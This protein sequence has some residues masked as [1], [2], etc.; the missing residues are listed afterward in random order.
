MLIE[1]DAARRHP[2][3]AQG[4]RLLVVNRCVKTPRCRAYPSPQFKEILGRDF[5]WNALGDQSGQTWSAS[6]NH[7]FSAS[8]ACARRSRKRPTYVSGVRRSRRRPTY[9]SRCQALKETTNLRFSVPGAQRKTRPE[10][11][12]AGRSCNNLCK[13]GPLPQ[14]NSATKL[15]VLA[16]T[17]ALLGR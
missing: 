14:A 7:R 8:R 17:T 4:R 6:G 3:L 11:V 5:R 12:G 10:L 13:L 2:E 1:G 16:R 9:A 15:L